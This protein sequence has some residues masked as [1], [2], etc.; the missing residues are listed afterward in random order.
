MTMSES[1]LMSK[2]KFEV[3]VHVDDY[4]LFLRLQEFEEFK[5]RDL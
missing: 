2:L 4:S 5:M 3:E 1:V